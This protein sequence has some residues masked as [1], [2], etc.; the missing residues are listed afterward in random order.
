[1][2]ISENT[3]QK[4]RRQG[5]LQAVDVRLGRR[6]SRW[7]KYPVGIPARKPTTPIAHRV[8]DESP[9]NNA[10]THETVYN[11]LTVRQTAERLAV[12]EITVYKWAKLGLLHPVRLGNRIVRF[13]AADID[14]ICSSGTPAAAT[15][16]GNFPPSRPSSS[17]SHASLSNRR[18]AWRE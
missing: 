6:N 10:G 1:M 5:Q 11:L 4:W 15:A 13:A 12:H 14:R 3:G 9:V 16:D 8:W 7:Q 2:A 17:R 18:R